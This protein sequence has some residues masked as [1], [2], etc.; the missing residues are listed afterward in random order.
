MDPQQTMALVHRDA[1]PWAV[2]GGPLHCSSLC[3]SPRA[4]RQDWRELA[5]AL[6][7]GFYQPGPFAGFALSHAIA[8][9]G[10]TWQCFQKDL[11]FLCQGEKQAIQMIPNMIG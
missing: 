6:C 1:D 7:T 2:Q 11:I 10:R 3:W 8:L 9:T 4:E 5:P